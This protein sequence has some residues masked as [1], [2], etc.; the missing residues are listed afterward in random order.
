MRIVPLLVAA[1]VVT[2][3]TPA[4]KAHYREKY[5][6]DSPTLVRDAAIDGQTVTLKPGQ[7]LVVR[8]EEDPSTGMR[9]EMADFKS[10]SVLATVQ[11][12]LVAK[13]GTNPVAL[14]VPGE[15]VFR[16]RGVASGTQAIALEYRRPLEA[17]TKTVRFEVVV[18]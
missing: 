15:G 7:A 9:W 4:Q 6:L 10:A 8:L 16:M 11:H 5:N 3:C 17:A 12:D 1:L 2:A 14:N 13:P 18:P